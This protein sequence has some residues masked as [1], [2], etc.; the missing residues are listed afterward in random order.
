MSRDN[1]LRRV[2]RR[3]GGWVKNVLVFTAVK[4]DASKLLRYYSR[5]RIDQSETATRIRGSSEAPKS[6]KKQW[7][8]HLKTELY[9]IVFAKG[10]SSVYGFSFLFFVFNF[11][12][13]PY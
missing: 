4:Q 10:V 9:N 2:A 6:H 5:L 13:F 1:I 12:K 8:V 3:L 7:S 11:R